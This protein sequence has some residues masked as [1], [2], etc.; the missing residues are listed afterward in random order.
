MGF[1]KSG[2]KDEI[3]VQSDVDKKQRVLIEAHAVAS[4]PVSELILRALRANKQ[5][6]QFQGIADKAGYMEV[7]SNNKLYRV[8]VDIVKSDYM[9][10]MTPFEQAKNKEYLLLQL[11]KFHSYCDTIFKVL[12]E[13]VSKQYPESLNWKLTLDKNNSTLYIDPTHTRRIGFVI[14]QA[15]NPNT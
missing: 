6:F 12:M 9:I 8:S 1:S 14:Q 15:K 10:D 4:K 3:D 5:N 11:S 2:E 13:T 7:R